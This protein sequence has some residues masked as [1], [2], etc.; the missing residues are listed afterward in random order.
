MA[1]KNGHDDIIRTLVDH[2]ANVNYQK[3]VCALL[4]ALKLVPVRHIE[5]PFLVIL[6]NIKSLV[7]QDK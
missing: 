5:V 6:R 4:L 1:T 3:M 7:T 2:G